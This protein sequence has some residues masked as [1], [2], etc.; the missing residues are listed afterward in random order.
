MKFKRSDRAPG[1]NSTVDVQVV[2]TPP[3]TL[4]F[5][6]LFSICFECKID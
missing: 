3:F 6:R 1:G 4:L 2:Y 5:L